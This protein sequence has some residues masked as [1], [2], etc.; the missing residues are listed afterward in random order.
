MIMV[1]TKELLD[2]VRV[3]FQESIFGPEEHNLFIVRE[4]CVSTL[5]VVTSQLLITTF[6]D[7]DISEAKKADGYKVNFSAERGFLAYKG[8]V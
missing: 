5:V 1:G 2:K 3:S 6:Q 8:T 4:L 7:E